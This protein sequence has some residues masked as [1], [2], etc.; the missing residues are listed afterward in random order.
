MQTGAPTLLER[1]DASVSSG[2]R[3]PSSSQARPLPQPMPLVEPTPGRS[4][5][6]GG[7]ARHVLRCPDPSELPD[8]LAAAL[9]TVPTTVHDDMDVEKEG[10]VRFGDSLMLLH[11]GTE[12]LLQADISSR[13]RVVD[14]AHPQLKEFDAIGVTTG[15]MLEPCARNT[16]SI[17][18]A[19]RTGDGYDDDNL[20]VH[21][22]QDVLLMPS[23]FLCS[24]LLHLH[25]ESPPEASEPTSELVF[26]ARAARR[27]RWRVIPAPVD[28][29][30]KGIE[31]AR[32]RKEVSDLGQVVRCNEKVA[33]QNVSTGRLLMSDLT[34]VSTGF[35]SEC[36]VYA[37]DAPERW[38]ATETPS[39]GVKRATWTFVNDHW[40]DA[41]ERAESST[42][43]V[44]AWTNENESAAENLNRRREQAH[45]ALAFR[46]PVTKEKE[47]REELRSRTLPIQASV[48]FK[49]VF[50]ALR[51]AGMHGVRKVRRACVQADP[52][53]VG[54]IRAR[55]FQG[56]LSVHGMRVKESEFQAFS[57]GFPAEN[58]GSD[59]FGVQELWV[60]YRAFFDYMEGVMPDARIDIIKQAYTKLHLASFDR[61]VIIQDLFQHWNPRCYSEVQAG[62]MAPSEV[63]QD[64][65]SQ[66]NVGDHEGRISAEDFMEYYR[67]V[68][69]T[70][71]DTEKF[72]AMMRTA[73]SLTA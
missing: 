22:G 8:E 1:M 14:D 18:R 49:D 32:A 31:A 70:Y 45:S 38:A 43:V 27:S 41:V 61:E 73:W 33:F 65:C 17:G 26:L 23:S 54:E 71:S 64:F 13:R 5:Q 36:R 66:W 52:E 69:L 21:Y 24:Q 10:A 11:H 28:E 16:F 15:R 29:D 56:F 57:R 35:G 39:L 44:T 20:E 25:V 60:S 34:L 63:F 72:I 59:Q 7:G 4:D 9:R 47:R 67:D 37:E 55:I 53:N 6:R 62:G 58:R 40:S 30:L 46:P 42:R 2:L 12:V 19:N 3:K 51:N 48:V 50:Q 68:S